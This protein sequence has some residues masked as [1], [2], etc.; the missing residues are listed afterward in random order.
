[1]AINGSYNGVSDSVKTKSVT[2]FTNYDKYI[3]FTFD[4]QG[5]VLKWD[6]H[7]VNFAE[8]KSNTLATVLLI[9]GAV[10]LTVLIVGSVIVAG[11]LGAI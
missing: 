3:K 10:A 2:Q 1:V 6:S 8:K 9:L 11:E 5:T 4:A 7:G